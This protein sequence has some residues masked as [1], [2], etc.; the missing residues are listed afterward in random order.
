MRFR[1]LALLDNLLDEVIIVSFIMKA[2]FLYSRIIMLRGIPAGS[3]VT[4]I[5]T[6][7]QPNC[8][9]AQFLVERRTCNIRK[10]L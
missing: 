7:R 9:G 2:D 4:G 5:E 1:R 6:C 8:C 3:G 10:R